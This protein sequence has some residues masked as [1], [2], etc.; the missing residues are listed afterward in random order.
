M[1]LICFLG[2]SFGFH[3]ALFNSL[4][5]SVIGYY[6]ELNENDLESIQR[7]LNTSFCLGGFAIC[8]VASFIY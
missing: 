5:N 1:V 7:I 3:M 2:F 6:K 8:F 4:T